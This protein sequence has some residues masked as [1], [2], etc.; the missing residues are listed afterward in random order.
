VVQVPEYLRW[1]KEIRGYY[2]VNFSL[3]L[4]VFSKKVMS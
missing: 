1:T 2:V 3:L 4:D